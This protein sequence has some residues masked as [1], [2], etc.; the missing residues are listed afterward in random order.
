M[1]LIDRTT[2]KLLASEVELADTF[3]R[4]LRGLM[5]RR[6]FERGK[7]LLFKFPKPA[8]YSVHMCF[9]RFPIDLIYLDSNFIVVEIHKRLKPWRAYRPKRIA[10]C[11]IEIPAGC[12]SRLRINLGDKIFLKKH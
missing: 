10:N 5:F 11:L 12:V 4:R 8:R 1:R 2:G 3:W 9:V 7:A 6:K